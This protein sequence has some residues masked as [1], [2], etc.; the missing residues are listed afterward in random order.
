MK[1][2]ARKQRSGLRDGLKKLTPISRIALRF[3]RATVAT[4]AFLPPH[5]VFRLVKSHL[6]RWGLWEDFGGTM[7]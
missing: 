7:R 1:P 4:L 5:G 3:I 6:V 2:V